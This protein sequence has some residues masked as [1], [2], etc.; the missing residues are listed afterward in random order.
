[1]KL[2]SFWRSLATF[3]VRIALN[4]KGLA[5]EVVDV[6]LLK[7]QQRNPDFRN[8]GQILGISN[9]VEQLRPYD[10]PADDIAQ[11]RA[12]LEAAEQGDEDQREAEH[13]RAAFEDRGGGLSSLGGRDHA[14]DSI[15]AR[16]ARNGSRIAPCLPLRE[17]AGT[18]SARPGHDGGASLPSSHAL[19]SF[20]AS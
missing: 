1:M 11:G 18:S 17:R 8:A 6:D 3:R 9:Q 19:S 20:S 16:R 14:A 13:D 7:G 10:S 12:E 4:L 15:A 2:Y 5:P